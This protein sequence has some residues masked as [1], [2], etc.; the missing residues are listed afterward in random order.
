MRADEL[1]ISK[2]Q[3]VVCN[4]RNKRGNFCCS[5]HGF[6]DKSRPNITVHYCSYC[7]VSYVHT[8]YEDGRVECD[9]VE[10]TIPSL[11]IPVEIVADDVYEHNNAKPD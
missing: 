1:D 7:K 6:I 9:V 5:Y 10:G 3:V 8:V 11:T 4:R 2:L